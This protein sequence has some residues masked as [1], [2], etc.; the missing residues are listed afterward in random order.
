MQRWLR[1]P[2]LKWAVMGIRQ[3]AAEKLARKLPELRPP[4]MEALEQKFFTT[5]ARV[6]MLYVDMDEQRKR[7][8][9]LMKPSPDAAVERSSE[10]PK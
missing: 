4:R 5:M 3:H 7:S 9:E 2:H 1:K 6:I 8:E 10:E